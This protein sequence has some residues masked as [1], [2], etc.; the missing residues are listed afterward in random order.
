VSHYFGSYDALV[1]QTL[2]RRTTR[3]REAALE[4]VATAEAV[5]SDALFDRIASVASDRITMRLAAW[6]LMT[7]RAKRSDFFSARTQ[8]LAAVVSAVGARR[9]ALGLPAVPRETLEFSVVATLTMILGFAVA[10]DALLAGLGHPTTGPRA[11]QIEADY[12]ARV[13]ELVMGYLALTSQS[14]GRR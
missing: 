4:E 3:M 12:R 1:E 7:G 6:A 2:E 10:K 14:S 8:G 11:A 13:R 9:E 5:G